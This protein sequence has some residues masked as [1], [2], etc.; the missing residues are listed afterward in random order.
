M[1]ALA[2]CNNFFASCERVF[3]PDLEGRPVIVLSNNDGC[4]VARSNEAKALGIK[5]GEPLF[6]IRDIVE[7]NGVAVF[8]S[9]YALYG[10]MSRRV[11]E[12]L[13]DFAP[14]VEQY[15]IDESFLDL[16][17][18][19]VEDL[20]AYARRIAAV[21]RK[22]TGIPLSVGVAPTKTLA[23]IASKLCKKYPKLEGGCYMHRPEDIE[24]VLRKFPVED[25][26][27]I[28]RRS[29]RKLA[30][31]GVVTAWDY[32]RLKEY[33]VRKIFAL[34]GWRTWRELR[35]EPCIG[36]EDMVEPRQTICVSR[37]FAKEITDMTDLCSQTATFAE[38]AAAKL[39]K[40]DSLALEMAVFAMTNRFHEDEPQ[41]FSSRLT[42]FPDGTD[43]YRTVVVAAAEV[44]RAMFSR[45]YGYKKAG[46]IFTRVAS[47]EGF[48]R[49]LFRDADA[50]MREARLSEAL[51][52]I[53]ASYGRGAVLFGV[54]G[55][56]SVKMSQEYQSP[57]YSTLWSDIPKVKIG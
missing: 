39:R 44:T 35:G 36:F 30:Q 46:V 57:H 45:R 5:I 47:R 12:V 42:V 22:M 54:Q 2:D 25:V 23:K 43:D 7:R 8:S 20:A 37:S 34:P 53:A 3:R 24:K 1:F 4:A 48:T 9:N 52:G 13:R 26:W 41:A 38:S 14:A 33:D 11:Q 27:G 55:D 10:D 28:G 49:S 40:Q 29:V 15:S 31:M 6:K 18:L 17:G 32:T 19:A 50:D 21:C 56:G 16:R 51:D